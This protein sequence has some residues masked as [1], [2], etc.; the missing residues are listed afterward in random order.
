MFKNLLQLQ[1]HFKDERVC[2]EYIEQQRWNGKPECPHCG[3]EHHYRTKTRLKSPELEGYKDFWCKGCGKKYTTL[4]GSIYESSKCSLQIWLS[5]IYLVTAHRKGISSVQLAKDLG[6]TQKTG[7]F[8]NHRIREMLKDRCPEALTNTVE[9]DETYLGKKFRSDFKGYTD[10]QV[11]ELKKNKAKGAQKA[12]G[13]VLGLMQREGKV[14]LKAFNELD[15]VTAKEHIKTHVVPGSKVYT[16]SSS[17]YHTGLDEYERE[18]VVHNRPTPEWVR[19]DV[20]VNTMESFWGTMKRGVYGIYHFISYK[21]L[22]AYCDEFS[23]RYNSRQLP[24]VERFG[25][26]VSSCGGARIRYKTLIGK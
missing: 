26:A 6:V 9:V 11:E 10:K 23:Y 12:K 4:T 19:G 15:G 18:S 22:Q 17:L 2:I 1:K 14:I 7:W 25:M 5:A 3:S 8:L 20:H 24:D 13:A 16:D 21:H